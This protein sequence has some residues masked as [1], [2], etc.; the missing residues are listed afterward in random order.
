MTLVKKRRVTGFAP[1]EISAR[2][3]EFVV[4]QHADDAAFLWTIRDQAVRAPN[5]SL[6]DLIRWDRRVEA[7]LDGLR[8]AG[9]FGWQLCARAM[10]REEPGEVFAASV[11]ALNAE[12]SARIHEVLEVGAA[13][14]LQRGL[15]SALGWLPFPEVEPRL[16]EFLR[17]P[18]PAV[19]RVGIAAH[20]VHRHDPGASLEAALSDADPR[21]RVRALEAVGELGRADLLG[22]VQRSIS[23]PEERV[24]F[25]AAWSATRLG[26]RSASLSALRGIASGSTEF[27]EP[28]MSM[29]L[30][31]MPLNESA[32]QYREMRADPQRQR[33]AVRAAG[34]VGDPGLVEDLIERAVAR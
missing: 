30:R 18:E 2:I 34:I 32:G 9:A 16:A 17:S 1:E 10:A 7:H 23:D 6:K 4:E 28:A 33:W 5:F 26:D 3:N 14:E 13:P 24:R 15:I 12:D 22:T 20:A 21:L 27:A 25:S 19:R 8:V 11:L 31:V 29:A